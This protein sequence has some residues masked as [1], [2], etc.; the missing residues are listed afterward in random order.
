MSNDSMLDI[1]LFESD[2]L[3][4]NLESLLLE[5][6]RNKAF[7][8]EQIADIFRI[9]HTIKGSSAMMDF[10]NIANIAHALEDLFDYLREHNT[11]KEDFS[12]IFDLSFITLDS[13][14]AE[15][16]KVQSNG[17]PDGDF[18]NIIK[19]IKEFNTLLNQRKDDGSSMDSSSSSFSG[20]AEYSDKSLYYKATVRFKQGCQMENVRA[21]GVIKSVESLCS[22]IEASPADLNN[23]T[24]AAQIIENGFTLHMLSEA[25]KDELQGV[26]KKTFFLD[27][28]S[29][30]EIDKS[31][32]SEIFEILS[33]E[34]TAQP[35]TA[36]ATGGTTTVKQNFMSVNLSKLDL[37][38]DLVGEIVI[39]QSTVTENPE[40]KKH[41]IA[42]FEK[43]SRQ[44][45]K[46]TNELQD[47]VMSIRMVPVAPTFLK[48][49]RVVRNML[50]KVDKKAN[51]NI[52]GQDTE[53]D[54]N[55]LDNLS[56]PLMHIIRNAVDH[57]I[58]TEQDR[59]KKG[60]DP[61]GNI[62]LEAR[63]TGGD[64][65]V[66]VT[67]D[68][69]GLNKEELIKKGISKGLITKP[70]SEVTDKE[71]YSIIFAAGFSTKKEVTEFS[72]RGVGM[73][74]AMK[75]IQKLGGSVSV[76]S[77]LGHGMSVQIRLPLTLAIIDGLQ[78]AVGEQSFII[79][80][81]SIKES[82]KPN[83]KDIFTDTDGNKN[84]YIRGECYPILRL[85]E[86]FNVETDVT[87][88]EDGI[89]VLVEAESQAYCIFVDKLIGDRQAVVK[90]IPVYISKILGHKKSISGCTIL[91]DGSVSLIL[92]INGL[93]A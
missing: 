3:L 80:L 32:A 42:S 48:M 89:L 34:K 72:G 90:P 51:M 19:D 87:E 60:K 85:H 2:Q 74:V 41:H 73:D 43:A 91:G 66:I 65:F 45:D 93:Y 17:L 86:A 64:V 61:V 31:K 55:I 23:N 9:L 52:I 71:A 37:L 62:T 8:S 67:D 63:N 18:S 7:S 10:D 77:T 22:H 58:E 79:P 14:K 40:V 56:D 78:V 6:E 81:L 76:S 5:C 35:K 4:Q 47:I 82:F 70:A 83:T 54:K 68:G 75:N 29:L 84:I 69:K 92:D 13:I 25:S 15:I 26:L 49:E 36:G 50:N 88:F 11:R 28:L 44:L 16:T 30:E 24:S 53:I 46:L 27:N 21:L 1:Y 39:A 20:K 12:K 59:I 38:M 57:G 33:P